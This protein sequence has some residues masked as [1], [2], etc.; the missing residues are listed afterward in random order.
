MPM[1]LAKCDICGSEQRYFSKIDNRNITPVCCGQATKRLIEAP[2]IQAQ[3]ISGIIMDSNG[4]KFEGKNAFE[5]HMQKNGL[6]SASEAQGEARI[7]NENKQSEKKKEI[8]KIVEEA[9]I[10]TG[11]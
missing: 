8:R 5:K 2:Q 9:A 7:Q 1:Y 6:I 10:K 4:D 11:V 3:T